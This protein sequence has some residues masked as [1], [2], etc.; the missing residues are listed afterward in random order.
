MKWYKE[1]KDTIE[2]DKFI[3]ILVKTFISVI[4]LPTFVSN[5]FESKD[6]IGEGCYFN[7]EMNQNK[8]FTYIK[9]S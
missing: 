6:N 9:A 4:S 7:S 2:F 1:N 5:S 3:G 8:T